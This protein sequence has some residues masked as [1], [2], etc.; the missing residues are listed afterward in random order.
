MAK[1][2]GGRKEGFER[3]VNQR[4]TPILIKGRRGKSG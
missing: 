2:F 1:P 3:G 4:P